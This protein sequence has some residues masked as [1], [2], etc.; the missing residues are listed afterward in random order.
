MEKNSSGV[1]KYVPSA[2]YPYR[3]PSLTS[4]D[5][6]TASALKVIIVLGFVSIFAIELVCC[7]L[8]P[9]AMVARV[10]KDELTGDSVIMPFP[11]FNQKDQLC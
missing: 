8:L 7:W 2:E 11:F 3:I 6:C 1:P 10:V 4:F 9:M 5:C